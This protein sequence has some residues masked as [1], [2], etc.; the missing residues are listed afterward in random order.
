ML[1][2]RDIAS[3]LQEG[4]FSPAN[5]DKILSVLG[6]PQKKV[7]LQIELAV[8]VHVDVGNQLIQATHSLEVTAL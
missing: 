1:Y 6:D 2:F 5:C 8:V 3:F 7:L 4:D